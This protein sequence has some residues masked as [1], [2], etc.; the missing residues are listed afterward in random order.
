M[1]ASRGTGVAAGIGLAASVV[2]TA[3]GVYLRASGAEMPPGIEASVFGLA[4]VGGAFL[5]SWAT[6]VA[7][8]DVSRGLALAIL[9]IVAVLPEYAVDL[10][11]AWAAAKRPEYGDFV[12]ANMTGANRLLVGV[13]WPLVVVLV[14]WRFRRRS[15]ALEVEDATGI[16]VLAI[17]SVYAFALPLKGSL[18][19]A[20]A[21]VLIGL[22]A[23]YLWR[24]GRGAVREPELLGPAALIGR[25]PRNARRLCIVAMFAWAGLAILAAAKPFAESLI[26]TGRALDVSEY[27]LVQWVAPLAS[28]AP[29]MIIVS[30]WA[31]RGDG[32]VALQAL[33]SSKINQWLLLVGTI[34]LVYSASLGRV[35]ALEFTT[36]QEHEV[37]LTAAQSLMAAIVLFNR[38]LN[39]LECALLFG[40]FAVQLVVPAIR[41]EATVAY[42]VLAAGY[43]LAYRGHVGEIARA[44]VGR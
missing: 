3:P 28:E 7:Q 5:L 38:S 41:L 4:I 10:Y 8:L 30:F 37:A 25:L 43:L 18:S 22:F 20:D 2:A 44:A 29:E 26:A 34:P 14:A 11:F 17:A 36:F 21:G 9:A 39:L 19:L 32:S 40:L 6:E 33:V 12:M 16:A 23:V 13:G 35:G 24:A 42:L 15:V 31:L 27:L 1:T